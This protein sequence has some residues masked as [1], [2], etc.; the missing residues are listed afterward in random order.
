MLFWRLSTQEP[1]NLMLSSIGS[2]PSTANAFW[3]KPGEIKS[4][5]PAEKP[6]RTV[7]PQNVTDQVL[8]QFDQFTDKVLK[9]KYLNEDNKQNLQGLFN[10]ARQQL[11]KALTEQ[12]TWA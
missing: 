8:N 12:Q 2:S 4:P 10:A 3:P 6:D 7:T 11:Q 1:D 9:N 5:Y